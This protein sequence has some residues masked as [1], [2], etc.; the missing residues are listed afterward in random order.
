MPLLDL[1]FAPRSRTHWAWLVAVALV[2]LGWMALTRA[3]A[4]ATTAGPP[5]APKQGFAAPDFTLQTLD[6]K[7][8][9]L[10]DLRGQVV[11][12]NFWATWCSP[13]KAEMP[14]MQQVYDDYHEQ[15]L[16][17]LAI[18][19]EHDT[20][21]IEAFVQKYALTFPILLDT[22]TTVARL[23]QVHG[24]PTT[25][26]VDRQGI[27]RWVVVGGPMSEGLL[28]SKVETLLQEEP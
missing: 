1:D 9:A 13:C 28:R 7:Q 17:I 5:P 6:G 12:I 22:E 11:V 14:A 25:F 2:G 15:G 21:A 19:V 24:T 20:A 8:I 18:T 26:F 3:P 10:Q 4:G 16:E 27:I 23:Y